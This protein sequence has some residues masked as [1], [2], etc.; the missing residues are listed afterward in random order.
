[1]KISLLFARKRSFFYEK[2]KLY[3]S[4]LIKFF[5]ENF[6]KN[7]SQKFEPK[8]EKIL[9]AYLKRIFP[10]TKSFFRVLLFVAVNL[11]VTMN[12]SVY[13]IQH[14]PDQSSL[15]LHLYPRGK[16]R[17][18]RKDKYRNRY[19]NHL[20]RTGRNR[21]MSCGWYVGWSI[22]RGRGY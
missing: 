5:C 12:F 11:H 7:F 16:C 9:K 3:S 4:I 17:I 8:V 19:T 1:M 20:Q 18:F 2:D 14:V 6:Q 13:L 15:Y 22:G 10:V 21:K